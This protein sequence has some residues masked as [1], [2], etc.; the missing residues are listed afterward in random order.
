MTI[1][2]F[3]KHSPQ[4]A[5]SAYIDHDAVVIG[6]VKIGEDASVWPM[7]VIRGDVNHIQIGALSNIQDGCILHVTHKSK[8]NPKGGPLLIGQGV[9]VGHGAILHACTIDDFCLVG[10]GSTLLDNA[11]MEHHSML[12][13]GSVLPPG[14]LIKTG[15]LWMGNPAKKVKMLTQSQIEYLEYSADQYVKLKSMYQR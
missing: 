5:H 3:N 13:A 4:I 6:E 2:T 8:A 7:S 1:R 15:E 9:T 11:K 14:K 10:M 12:G